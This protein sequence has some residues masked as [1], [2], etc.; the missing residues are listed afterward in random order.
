MSFIHSVSVFKALL[1]TV[2]SSSFGLHLLAYVS[3]K[4]SLFP[5]VGF[6]SPSWQNLSA[7]LDPWKYP[8]TPEFLKNSF[9]Y[10]K[11]HHHQFR[12]HLQN[13]LC[14]RKEIKCNTVFISRVSAAAEVITFHTPYSDLSSVKSY[15]SLIKVFVML[16]N[17]TKIMRWLQTQYRILVCHT[18]PFDIHQTR[19]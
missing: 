15:Q 12:S 14:Q 13:L 7:Q 16:H 8:S 10:I 11:W 1:L 18:R 4:A 6:P 2:F 17:L 5:T 3:Q 9:Q 19:R